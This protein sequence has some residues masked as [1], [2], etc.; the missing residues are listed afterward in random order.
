MTTNHPPI[1]PTNPPTNQP[2]THQRTNQPT[3]QPINYTQPITGEEKIT[4]MID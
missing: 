3:T 2:P 4:K 1:Y